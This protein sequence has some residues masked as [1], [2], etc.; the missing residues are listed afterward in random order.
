MQVSIYLTEDLLKKVDTLAQK[1]HKSRS[2][3]IAEMIESS[4][5][6]NRKA[7]RTSGRRKARTD[8]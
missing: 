2:T 4:L 7:S 5:G 3:V 8:R 6:G 1:E